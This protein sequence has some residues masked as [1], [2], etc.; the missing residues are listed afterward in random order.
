MVAAR[1]APDGQKGL[2]VL[3]K[4]PSVGPIM[5]LPRFEA[6]MAEIT[7][8]IAGRPLDAELAVWLN[9][10]FPADGAT[11]AAIFGACREAIAAGWM[12]H[13]EHAGIKYGRVI[14][15]GPATHG[16]SVDVVDMDEVVGGHH[17]HPNGEIDLVMPLSDSA[18][19]DGHGAGWCVYP[20][21]SAHSPTV[22]GGRAFVLY[23]LPQGAIQFTPAP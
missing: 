2:R 12:C 15:P 7:A 9:R 5:D 6:L 14:K 22:T 20:P 17:I 4:F 3:M 13:R 8:N 19:F 1:R 16:F 21:G 10:E 23:L 18:K 11:F